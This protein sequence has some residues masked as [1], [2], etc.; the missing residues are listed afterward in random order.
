MIVFVLLASPR[1]A[2]NKNQH[3]FLSFRCN[4][5]LKCEQSDAQTFVGNAANNLVSGPDR[6]L[7]EVL[8]VR[9]MQRLAGGGSEDCAC[10]AP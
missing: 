1:P 9:V 5:A 4:I 7:T 10:A 2:L 3:N 8:L 6:K